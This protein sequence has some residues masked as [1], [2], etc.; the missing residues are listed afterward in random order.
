MSTLCDGCCVHLKVPV[1]EDEGDDEED[2]NSKP[3]QETK[4]DA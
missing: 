2:N 4:D 3:S 1:E